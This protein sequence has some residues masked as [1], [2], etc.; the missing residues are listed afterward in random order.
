MGKTM[1]NT[2]VFFVLALFFIFLTLFFSGCTTNKTIKKVEIDIEKVEQQKEDK[3]I[4]QSQELKE[5]EKNL[6][7][8]YDRCKELKNVLERDECYLNMAIEKNEVEIC[9]KIYSIENLDKCL[10]S[11]SNQMPNLC[12]EINSP[13]LREECYEKAAYNT[14]NVSYCFKLQEKKKNK[15]LEDLSPPC[16]FEKDEFSTNLCYAKLYNDTKYCKNNSDCIFEYAIQKNNSEE[17]EKIDKSQLAK[18]LACEALATSNYNKCNDTNLTSVSDR[19]YEIVAYYTENK[20]F[21]LYITPGTTYSDSCIKKFAIKTKDYNFC[22]KTDPELNR[23]RCYRDYSIKT[24]NWSVCEKIYSSLIKLECYYNTALE[25]L[26]LDACNYLNY[27]ARTNCLNNVLNSNRTL[28]N[29]EICSKI[30]GEDK[31]NWMDK[32]YLKYAMDNK[33]IGGCSYIED[34][35]KQKQCLDIFS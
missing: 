5:Q 29:L 9:R 1:R 32:C 22:S 8:A 18:F 25:N 4:Q 26:D 13:L 20:E 3:Q 35:N 28:T 27:Q 7:I 21:C 23:D 12:Y 16:T 14:N 15:C 31:Q 34:K 6:P 24:G 19:C 11:F 17:C 30:K 10:F 33:D 2:K